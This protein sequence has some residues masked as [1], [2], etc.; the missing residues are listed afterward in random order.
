MSLS[1]KRSCLSFACAVFCGTAAFTTL[2]P[3]AHADYTGPSEVR[4][5]RT[6][7][8][9]LNDPV[10]DTYVTLRGHITLQLTDKTYQFSDGTGT[11]LVRIGPKEFGGQRI[12]DKTP[13]EIWGDTHQDPHRQPWRIDVKRLTVVR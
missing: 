2:L 13:V 6:V 8:D 10:E 1:L 12:D 4:Q 5:Y 3:A 11:I 7:A 9:I